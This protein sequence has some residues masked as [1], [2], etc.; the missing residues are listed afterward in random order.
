MVGL[1]R[2]RRW[3]RGRSPDGD[4]REANKLKA[5]R[6]TPEIKPDSS[7][8]SRGMTIKGEC[9][10]Q[11]GQQRAR[12]GGHDDI[13]GRLGNGIAAA[14]ASPGRPQGRR[15]ARG[16]FVRRASAGRAIT[17]LYDLPQADVVVPASRRTVNWIP[18]LRP[19][20]RSSR[21]SRGCPPVRNPPPRDHA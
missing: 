7:G 17:D 9:G 6:L 1:R 16:P 12:P 5:F 14:G 21:I 15:R 10:D 18:Q 13:G 20:C 8:S 19:G 4:H 11:I 2:P 3:R